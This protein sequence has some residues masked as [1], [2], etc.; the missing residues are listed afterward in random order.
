MKRRPLF[1][2]LV[3][4]LAL[5]A[6]DS[7]SDSFDIDDY[8][9]TYRGTSTLTF[10]N[11]PTTTTTT[12]PV[13][14][15]IAKGTANTVSATIDAGPATTGGDDP[16]PVVFPGT[17]SSTGARFAAAA[18]GSSVVITVDDGGDIDGSGNID[19]FGVGLTLAPSGRITGTSFRLDVDLDVTQGNADVPTGSTGRIVIDATR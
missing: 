16:A 13:T 5:A 15:T 8:T 3:S 19:L 7:S 2:A 10:Q 18:P 6:C 1:A 17:Y 11:G 14:V 4:L 9:G 12:A